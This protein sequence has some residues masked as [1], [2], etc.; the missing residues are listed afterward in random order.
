MGVRL[1]LPAL[2]NRGLK[3]ENNH[4]LYNAA[5]NREEQPIDKQIYANW[6]KLVEL[7]RQDTDEC[8]Q[9][10]D[11]TLPHLAQDPKFVKVAGAALTDPNCIVRDLAASTFESSDI[12]PPNDVL[13]QLKKI[14]FAQSPMMTKTNH[15]THFTLLLHFSNTV[16]VHLIL[17]R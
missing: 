3:T 7:A 9:E 16:I 15:M 4:I 8:W 11:E 14:A 5:M 17:L 10:I 13:T 2:Q 12:T 6:Q 1:P